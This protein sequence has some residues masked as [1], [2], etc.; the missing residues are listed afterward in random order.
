MCCSIY[1]SH[2]HVDLSIAADHIEGQVEGGGGPIAMADVTLWVAGS[3]APRK[4]AETRTKDEG[5]R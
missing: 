1:S 4:L 3:G 2:A 5:R